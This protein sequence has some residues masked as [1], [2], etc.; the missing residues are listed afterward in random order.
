MSEWTFRCECGH[1][2]DGSYDRHFEA[3]KKSVTHLLEN[4]S[5]GTHDTEIYDQDNDT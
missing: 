3:V 4:G 5:D 2:H 1:E